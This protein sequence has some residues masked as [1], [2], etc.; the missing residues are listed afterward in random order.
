MH[1]CCVSETTLFSDECLIYLTKW[2]L[3]ELMSYMGLHK[4]LI[5]YCSELRKVVK[6]TGNKNT[7]SSVFTDKGQTQ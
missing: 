6:D 7:S 1:Q 5:F 2:C 3:S 4:E